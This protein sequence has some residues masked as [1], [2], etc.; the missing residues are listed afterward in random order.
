M[1]QALLLNK[2]SA[3]PWPLALALRR[4]A[5]RAVRSVLRPLRPP[6]SVAA[7][8]P[9]E[10]HPLRCVA[11]GAPAARRGGLAERTWPRRHRV[12]VRSDLLFEDEGFDDFW[13]N[14]RER[15]PPATATA[16]V[17]AT[18]A[19]WVVSAV[20]RDFPLVKLL[21]GRTL[22]KTGAGVREKL[23]DCSAGGAKARACAPTR[24]FTR[25]KPSPGGHVHCCATGAR[26]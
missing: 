24:T 12:R 23:I 5:A 26:R 13:A 19:P 4:A 14:L 22:H 8:V 25:P 7:R 2:A 20:Q 21:R 10:P 6:P 11:C 18:L 1:L 16:F 15:L 9:T 17:T 3:Q